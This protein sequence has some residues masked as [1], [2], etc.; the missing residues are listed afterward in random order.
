MLE[1]IWFWVMFAVSVLFYAKVNFNDNETIGH[2]I[3]SVFF[4]VV[5]MILSWNKIGDVVLSYILDFLPQKGEPIYAFTALILIGAWC[6]AMAFAL[7]ML[8][9]K[10]LSAMWGDGATI[11]HI[12]KEYGKL[13]EKIISIAAK[14]PEIK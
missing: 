1:Y 11:V 13:S 2:Y 8:T 12:W 9:W 6:I 5:A 3:G 10:V 7:P 14:K 4:M